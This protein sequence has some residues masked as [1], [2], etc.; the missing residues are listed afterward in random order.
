MKNILIFGGL[1]FIGSNIVDT[2]VNEDQLYNLIVFDFPGVINCYGTKIKMIFGDFNNEKDVEAVI[3]NNKIDIVIH[4]ISTTIPATSNNNII[5]DIEANLITSVRLLQ[6][7][8]KYQIPEIIFLSSGGTVYGLTESESVNEDHPTFPI[9]SHG[10]IKL[11]T[12]KY[13]QLFH[14]IYGL[15]YLILRAGNPY[16]PHQKSNNQGIINVFLRKIIHKGKLIIR[17]DGSAI[18]DYFYVKDLAS[19]IKILIEN[20]IEN[21]IINI[22]SGQGVSIN[23]VLEFLRK[24]NNNIE[25]EYTDALDSDVP[26]IVLDIKKLNSLIKFNFCSLEE[27]IFKTYNNMLEQ[28]L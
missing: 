16:G 21:E 13:I 6:L 5:Y 15:N 7:L 12:E 28:K 23:Q 26:Q 24:V 14:Q 9:S 2:L 11:C 27:G 25:V 20:E 10:V 4:L 8:V 3:K 18:R 22:G 19:I 1:G 17:G